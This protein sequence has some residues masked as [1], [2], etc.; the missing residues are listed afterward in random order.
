MPLITSAD[1]FQNPHKICSLLTL[2]LKSW[3]AVV[4]VKDFDN[5]YQTLLLLEKLTK[6]FNK[7]KSSK[8]RLSIVKDW[9][10]IKEG[11][12]AFFISKFLGQTL[13]QEFKKKPIDKV[14]KN[15]IIKCLNGF[16]LL[17]EDEKLYWRDLAPRNMFLSRD[18]KRITLIDFENLFDT[19]KM[20]PL[21]RVYWDKFRKVW[22]SDVLEKSEIDLI[23]RNLPTFTVDKNKILDADLLEKNY[24]NKKKITTELHLDFLELTA[25]F[26]KR[27]ILGKE[28][29]YGHRLG[30]Y[31]SDFHSSDDESKVYSAMMDFSATNWKKFLLELQNLVN[32]EQQNYL[33]S[34]Y[35]NKKRI[36]EIDKLFRKIGVK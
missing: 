26:E 8:I 33:L 25:N 30:L 34:I 22:F 9:V 29:V 12:R 19:T 36:N 3:F 17:C 16:A 7:G 4:E 20:L 35:T 14:T 11:K 1:I 2:D 6:K 24:F 5:Y 15:E 32:T 31:L 27:H 10:L 13:E 18:K 23:Y 21:T 28:I